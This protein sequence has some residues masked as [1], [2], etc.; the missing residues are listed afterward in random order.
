MNA[1]TW[2]DLLRG[3]RRSIIIDARQR[4]F[5]LERQTILRRNLW[6]GQK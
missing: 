4:Q 3:R 6:T 2:P 5:D 1:E